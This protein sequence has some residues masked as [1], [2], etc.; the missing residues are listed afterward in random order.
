MILL[1]ISDSISDC[2][3]DFSASS[4][5]PCAEG[6]LANCLVETSD[7]DLGTAG[8]IGSNIDAQTEP[9]ITCT[10]GT[11]TAIDGGGS[12]NRMLRPHSHAVRYR[13]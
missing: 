11:G 2:G 4:V 1:T 9:V 10:P 5:F 6:D 7:L 12:D 8:I 3:S 13:L